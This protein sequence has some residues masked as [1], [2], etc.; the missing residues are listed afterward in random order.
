[1]ANAWQRPA[2]R[3]AIDSLANVHLGETLT[4]KVRKS[5][6]LDDLDDLDFPEFEMSVRCNGDCSIPSFQDGPYKTVSARLS[7]FEHPGTRD[8]TH[9]LNRT[10]RSKEWCM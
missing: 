10:P 5:V 2:S 7:G 8:L 3:L 6:D 1:M 4:S 9:G